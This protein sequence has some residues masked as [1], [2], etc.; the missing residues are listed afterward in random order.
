MAKGKEG[1]V[2]YDGLLTSSQSYRISDADS[3]KMN[4]QYKPVPKFRGGCK[5]C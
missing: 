3:R 1:R 4:K 5:N 2:I